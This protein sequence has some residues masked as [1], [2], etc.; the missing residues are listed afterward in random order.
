M[1][2]RLSS[3]PSPSEQSSVA[4]TTGS[5]RS[6]SLCSL[7]SATNLS[8]S[9]ENYESSW[10]MPAFVAADKYTE[11]NPQ[12]R[13]AIGQTIADKKG[14]LKEVHRL[15]ETP[16]FELRPKQP[17][18]APQ[19]WV[20]GQQMVSGHS[21]LH[22]ARPAGRATYSAIKKYVTCRVD[23]GS[24]D[25]PRP[26]LM[27]LAA[28]VEEIR[29]TAQFNIALR[30]RFI[31]LVERHRTDAEGISELI[32]QKVYCVMSL[33]TGSL[34]AIAPGIRAAD[35]QT[36]ARYILR[37]VA[38]HAQEM[39]AAQYAHTDIKP[40]NVLL[41]VPSV[42]KRGAP[43]MVALCDFG[44]T[45][46]LAV[47]GTPIVQKNHSLALTGAIARPTGTHGYREMGDGGWVQQIDVDLRRSDVLAL[48]RTILAVY[49]IDNC[50]Q[51]Q[52]TEAGV[53][54][55]LGMHAHLGTA[56]PGFDPARIMTWSGDAARAMQKFY[57][58]DAAMFSLVIQRMEH[59]DPSARMSM[60]E[61]ALEVPAP[62]FQQVKDGL[63]WATTRAS[64]RTLERLNRRIELDAHIEAASKR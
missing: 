50:W 3:G 35:Q 13:Q 21:T 19:H 43:L 23:D 10:R 16:V 47:D 62:D 60:A 61:V 17:G 2:N 20:T 46:A 4:G 15:P 48:G 26:Q 6:I 27:T 44:E 9:S 37:S 40:D 24:P 63:V 45:T 34:A 11:R 1:V 53:A 58:A 5:E 7:P 32:S 22:L 18:A 49:G 56:T 14:A 41:D 33:K 30:P 57:Q 54:S 42:N 52:S 39:H 29:L 25:K 59:P 51:K 8:E 38:Q 28:V 55:W 64:L 36:L 31:Y 12:H